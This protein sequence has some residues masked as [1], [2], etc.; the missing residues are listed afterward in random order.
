MGIADLTEDG[1]FRL[2]RV[3]A[4]EPGRPKAALLESAVAE[5]VGP[6]RRLLLGDHVGGFGSGHAGIGLLLGQG[7]RGTRPQFRRWK[8]EGDVSRRLRSS[9]QRV[10]DAH[11]KRSV[12][13][14]PRRRCTQGAAPAPQA[15][16]GATIV[17]AS[18]SS[19][20]S[21]GFSA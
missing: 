18:S 20:G 21:A 14:Q 10:G 8:V 17:D 9:P 15:A 1:P 6:E 4:I 12:R 16:S 7:E 13:R 3:G 11:A 2:F 19:V 5:R